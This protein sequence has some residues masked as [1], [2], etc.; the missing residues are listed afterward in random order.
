MKKHVIKSTNIHLRNALSLYG[1]GAFK[2]IVV[3]WVE[4]LEDSLPSAIKALL[5]SREQIYLDWLFS[6]PSN[7]RLN[8][9]PLASGG[10]EGELGQH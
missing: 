2:F 8:F 4:I 3:E 9:L 1:I 6:L 5:L 7:K 10:P